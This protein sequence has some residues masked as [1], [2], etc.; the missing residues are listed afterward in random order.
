M[1]EVLPEEIAEEIMHYLEAHPSA[2]D[3]SDG[4]AD[5]WIRRQRYLLGLEKVQDAL[6]YLEQKGLVK[7]RVNPDG[8]VV[9]SAK[10][11]R[12]EG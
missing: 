11:K 12:E 6:N 5:W 8:S 1:H 3:T 2:C 9:Y 4:I 7:R 10:T